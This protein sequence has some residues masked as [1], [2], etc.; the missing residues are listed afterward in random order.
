M[1]LYYA[2]KFESGVPGT[3]LIAVRCEKCRCE[4]F[5]KLARVGA[6]SA[7][8]PYGIGTKRAARV[9]DERAR[10][11][12]EKRLERDT[13]IVPCPRCGWI[14]DDMVSRYRLGRYR[15]WTM[16]AVWI[17]LLGTILPLIVA[18]FLSIGPAADRGSVPYWMIGGP[19]ASVGLAALLLLS[20]I[21]LRK[22]IQPNRDYPLPPTLPPGGPTP[23]FMDQT[24]GQLVDARPPL[25]PLHATGAWIDFQ[26]GGH[27][28]PAECCACLGPPDARSARRLSVFRAAV[29]VVPLCS[30]CAREWKVRMWLIGLAILGTVLAL[31]FLVLRLAAHDELAFRIMFVLVCGVAPLLCGLAAYRLTAPVL[32]KGVD[33]SRALVRLRFRSEDYRNRVVQMAG[34]RD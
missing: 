17:A 30:R 3:R 15:R 34:A 18:W 10:R 33:F 28:L 11:D 27:Q 12:L 14:N 21:W 9:A 4:Y 31:A 5:F 13:E 22:R 26:I 23:L 29:V 20:R 24:T 2:R 16:Y 6:G 7:Q 32:V 19:A 25:T 8:A 1:I